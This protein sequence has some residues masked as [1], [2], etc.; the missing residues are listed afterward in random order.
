MAD[1]WGVEG[2]T[3]IQLEKGKGGAQEGVG[4]AKIEENK[5][6]TVR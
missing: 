1:L 2:E 4:A 3:H 6:R 5:E